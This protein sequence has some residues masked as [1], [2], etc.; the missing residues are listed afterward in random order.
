MLAIK[1]DAYQNILNFMLVIK[2]FGNQK[3]GLSFF[4]VCSGLWISWTVLSPC[5]NFIGSNAGSRTPLGQRGQ[6]GISQRNKQRDNQNTPLHTSM[7]SLKKCLFV[8]KK[9]R[10]KPG[11]KKSNAL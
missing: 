3:D 9:K 11:F 5:G 8:C 2:G 7:T 1:A 6:V 4:L 10:R